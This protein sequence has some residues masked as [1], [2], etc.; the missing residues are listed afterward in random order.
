MGGG[1]REGE[2]LEGDDRG[3]RSIFTSISLLHDWKADSRDSHYSPE[4]HGSNDR[5]LTATAVITVRTAM[6][7]HNKP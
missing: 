1:R 6:T 3:V 7:F 2:K 4:N 5:A